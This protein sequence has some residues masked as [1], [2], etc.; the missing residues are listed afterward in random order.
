MKGGLLMK[1]L[2]TRKIPSIGVEMLKEKHDVIENL[3][4]VQMTKEQL[5]EA[6]SDVDAVLSA[7]T[8]P[9]DE[10]VIKAGKNLKII[11]NYAVGYNNIDIMAAHSAGVIVTNT[12]DILSDTTA[13]V[14]WA[15]L[16][17]VSRRIVEA[18]RYLRNGKWRTFTSDLMLGQ[19]IHDKTLGIIGAGRIGRRFAEK[20]RGYNMSI[21]YHNREQA[22]DFEKIHNARYVSL[23]ELLKQSDIVSIH[24]PLTTETYHLIGENELR[25]MKE[26]AILINTSRGPILDEKALAKA[27]KEHW[28]FGAGLDVYENEPHVT[29]ELLNLDNVVLLPHIGSATHET[30]NNMSVLCARNIIQVLEGRKP[31][32]PVK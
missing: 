25:M 14:A 13:E 2:I 31:S 20:A 24:V 22:M 27:L 21:L 28:I 8:D 12:P 3:S 26:N 29:P 32:T 18:D 5:I 11:S 17:A 23:E 6:V 10:T 15:L 4:D 16:F 19:D 9:I 30:R 7:L 1:V